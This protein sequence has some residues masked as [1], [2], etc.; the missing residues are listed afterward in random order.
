MHEL[1][2]ALLLGAAHA[3]EPGHGKGALA[4]RAGTGSCK[5]SETLLTALLSVV[6]HALQLGAFAL[7]MHYLLFHAAGEDLEHM[8]W[9]L[10]VFA[11][12]ALFIAALFQLRSALQHRTKA[13][14]TDSCSCCKTKV[15]QRDLK[16]SLLIALS[17]GLIPC[18]TALP[19][20]FGA[21]AQS[22]PAQVALWV[23]AFAVGMAITLLSVGLASQI[24]GTKVF[25]RI[26]RS[27]RPLGHL[28]TAC[29]FFL[30]AIQQWSG[31]LH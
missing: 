12:L 7:G 6:I 3:I 10:S 19:I 8:G 14:H 20:F 4:I 18:P 2:L 15:A 9:H 17:I 11:G 21:V 31:S 5:L 28:V 25:S 30:L 13:N 27:A 26:S 16:G 22:G 23:A 1:V 24:V 29:C